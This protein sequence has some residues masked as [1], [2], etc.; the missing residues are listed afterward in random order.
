[1]QLMPKASN[2]CE[3]KNEW[4]LSGILTNTC[5]PPMFSV[6]SDDVDGRETVFKVDLQFCEEGKPPFTSSVTIL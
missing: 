6:S 1:M 5:L 3:V 4:V 2:L